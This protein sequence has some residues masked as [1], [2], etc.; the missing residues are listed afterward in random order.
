VHVSSNVDEPLSWREELTVTQQQIDAFAALSGD[1]N[2]LHVDATFA[3]TTRFGRTIAHGGVVFALV[4]A[5]LRRHHPSI[6]L[7]TT[8][9]SFQSPVRSGDRITVSGHIADGLVAATVTGPDG[10]VACEFTGRCQ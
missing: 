3:A 7:A 10:H 2:P 1:D 4:R 9:L 8:E 6:R 5:G